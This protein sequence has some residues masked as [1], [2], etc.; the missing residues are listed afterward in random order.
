M[1]AFPLRIAQTWTAAPTAYIECKYGYL[2]RICRR[3]RRHAFGSI[4]MRIHDIWAGRNSRLRSRRARRGVRAGAVA[5]ALKRSGGA[6]F[7]PGGW[8]ARTVP[9]PPS[10]DPADGLRR[11]AWPDRLALSA[12]RAHLAGSGTG[13]QSADGAVSEPLYDEGSRL[14]FRAAA[15][16]DPPA[17]GKPRPSTRHAPA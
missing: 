6:S 3:S 14:C 2:E 8:P 4:K 1:W 16:P 12:A 5:W 9:F 10:P 13:P 7:A 17:T 11:A 15:A